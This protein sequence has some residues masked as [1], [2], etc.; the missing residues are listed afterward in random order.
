M[1]PVHFRLVQRNIST[2]TDD[3][4][5]PREPQAVLQPPHE[6]VASPK[7]KRRGSRAR[8]G[9]STSR[10]GRR[11]SSITEIEKQRRRRSSIL[12]Q[13]HAQ[14]VE[15]QEATRVRS[16]PSSNPVTSFQVPSQL[17][18]AQGS[19]SSSEDDGA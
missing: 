10:K 1:E 11:R 16:K 8:R 9:S 15:R 5:A 3:T 13:E 19:G 7:R 14:L 12:F 6:P 2:A 18:P 4:G 17:S